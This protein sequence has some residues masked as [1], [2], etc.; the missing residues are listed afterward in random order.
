MVV[1]VWGGKDNQVKHRRFW[2]SGIILYET[3]IVD[4][5]VQTH[6]MH[7]EKSDPFN[8]NCGLLL[9]I[10]YPCWLINC[11]KCNT[12]TQRRKCGDG[13]LWG[14]HFVLKF[15]VHLKFL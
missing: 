12:L 8:V 3:L 1:R 10:M 13:V 14:L 2:G 5:F 4:T 9:I 11:N 6:R 15:P 7:R